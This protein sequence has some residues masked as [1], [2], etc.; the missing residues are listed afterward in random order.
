MIEEIVIKN[1]ASYDKDGIV[2][3]GLNALNFIYG[4]NGSGKTT[5]SRFLDHPGNPQFESCSIKWKDNVEL[6]IFVYNSDF[7]KKNFDTDED[8][9]LRGI[10]TLGNASIM[11]QEDLKKKR[12]EL[13]DITQKLSKNQKT[14]SEMDKQ[15]DDLN[16][17]YKNILWEAYKNDKEIFKQAFDRCGKKQLFFDKIME[18][19][20]TRF[21]DSSEIER[22]EIEDKAK[23]LFGEKKEKKEQIPYIEL[24]NIKLILN[25]KIWS[26]PIVGSSDVEISKLINL[27]KNADWVNQG[28]KYIMD[29]AICPF[30]QKNTIDEN[31]R[32]QLTMFFDKE[33][34]V[35]VSI[36]KNL[37][38]DFEM[39]VSQLR[40]VFQ[41]IIHS[42]EEYLNLD[43]INS[44]IKTIETSFSR[45]MLLMDEKIKE[46][47][48]RIEFPNFEDSISQANECIGSANS[49]IDSYNQMIGNFEIETDKLKKNIWKLEVVENRRE[50]ELYKKEMD[51]IEKGRNGVKKQS[52]ANSE[53]LNLIKKEIVE[54]NRNLT[55][56]QPA[57]DEINRII[58]S[59]GFTN[60]RIV[61]SSKKNYYQ[62]K[63]EDGSP[64]N[65]TLSEGESTLITF[66][67]FLQL[68]KGS[69]YDTRVEENRIVVVDDPISSLDSSVL[70]LVSTLLKDCMRS[71]E[72]DSSPKIKQFFILTHNIYFHKELTYWGNGKDQKKEARFWILRKKDNVSNIDPYGK[73]NPVSNTYQLLW[74]ELKNQTR[75]SDVTIQNTMRRI[76]E[77]YFKT[78]GGYT[79]EDII[80]FF[81]DYESKEICR[82]L[83]SWVNDGSH[84]LT[85]D[86]FVEMPTD[87]IGKYLSV[88]KKIFKNSQHIKH[89]EMM[90]GESSDE[91]SE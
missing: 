34:T 30:C 76:I 22:S 83:L 64:A 79:D 16:E 20:N 87:V 58:E 13:D 68:I 24:H 74:K 3:D 67:Y 36:L 46:P 4:T 32:K 26:K 35:Q 56:V 71:I 8:S 57:I 55:S 39:Q 59:Y 21:D 85:D 5:I 63:R 14:L 37:R 78:F 47:G 43:L 2:I 7:K 72:K 44:I 53:K 40:E 49:K 89:Y 41:R 52:D 66:L 51:N 88:F 27:L 12:T 91:K 28:R 38:N 77:I 60:F 84:S 9:D 6:P 65:L 31:F 33:Y 19:Y 61:P 11:E 29:N 62:I 75:N 48:K 69:I 82:S 42:E 90:M 45:V 70:F 86:L 50:L 54:M 73:Q 10:F 17:K 1:T 81:P 18:I 80:N 25:D 15:K 23:T